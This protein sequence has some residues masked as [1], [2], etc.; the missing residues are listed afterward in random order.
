MTTTVVVD[1]FSNTPSD[2]AD[3]LGGPELVFPTIIPDMDCSDILLN[4]EGVVG[5]LKQ[6]IRGDDV[7]FHSWCTDMLTHIFVK[8]GYF[9]A[10]EVANYQ[11]F[12]ATYDG[13]TL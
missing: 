11:D 7:M 1:P 2:N 10:E 13:L 4:E 5:N 9:S 12:C 3:T 8:T 6:C